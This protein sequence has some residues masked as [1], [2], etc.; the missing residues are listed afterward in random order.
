MKKLK[1]TLLVLL[2]AAALTFTA[3]KPDAEE[4]NNQNNN[5]TEQTE[6]ESEEKTDDSDKDKTEESEKDADKDKETEKEPEKVDDSSTKLPGVWINSAEN[7]KYLFTADG[8]FKCGSTES[9][10]ALYIKGTYTVADSKITFNAT[11][12]SFD[13]TNWLTKADIESSGNPYFAIIAASIFTGYSE[14]QLSFT[15]TDTSLTLTQDSETVNFAKS[16]DTDI[17]FQLTVSLVGNWEND[18][19][20]LLYL[21][22][23]GEFISKVGNTNCTL[24]TYSVNDSTITI[25]NKQT[26]DAHFQTTDITPAQTTTAS[27]VYLDGTLVLTSNN[28]TIILSLSDDQPEYLNGKYEY[29]Y[30]NEGHIYVDYLSADKTTKK[31]YKKRVVKWNCND[32]TRMLCNV[33]SSF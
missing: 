1:L 22:E 2:A 13:N 25:I 20:Y 26:A 9:N 5:N 4:E 12:I 10:S 3:C 18:N 31:N 16:T 15:V 28:Q 17:T 23:D 19:G 14:L 7:L 32:H 30:C 8:N 27:F 29:S 6:K 11:H 24:G 21:G 33:Q